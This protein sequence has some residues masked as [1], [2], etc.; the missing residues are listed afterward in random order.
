MVGEHVISLHL[1]SDVD[2]QLPLTVV[3]DDEAATGD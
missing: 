2:V 1:H 3:A